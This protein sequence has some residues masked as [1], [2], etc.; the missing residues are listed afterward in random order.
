MAKQTRVSKRESQEK[1]VRKQAWNVLGL[2][3]Q[4]ICV[5]CFGAVNHKPKYF[6]PISCKISRETPRAEK[7]CFVHSFAPVLAQPALSVAYYRCDTP[8][9]VI[10][11][12]HSPNPQMVRYPPSYLVSHRRI[13]EIAHFAKYRA[14]IISPAKIRKSVLTDPA[15]AVP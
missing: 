12:K 7:E 11:C 5:K 4:E 8:Y 3:R 13:Y 1:K 15:F 9:R 2:S 10:P 6:A 14:I